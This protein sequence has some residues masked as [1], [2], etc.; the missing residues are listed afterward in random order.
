MK[1][2]KQIFD[3]SALLSLFKIRIPGSGRT[4]IEEHHS[5]LFDSGYQG[6][7]NYITET[8]VRNKLFQNLEI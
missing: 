7:M 2:E 8:K 1:N 5:C 6:V 4:T 3:D